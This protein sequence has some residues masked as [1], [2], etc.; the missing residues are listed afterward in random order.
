M[1]RVVN[2]Y[3]SDRRDGEIVVNIMRGTA[4]GNPFRPRDRS[5]AERDRVCDLYTV[6]LRERYKDQTSPQRHELERL[7]ALV[8]A[9]NSIAL[10]CCCMPKRCHGLTVMAAINGIINR[11]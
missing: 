6:W 3:H 4:L 10:E 7:A 11:R 8:K 5:D 1:I 9:G 2:K